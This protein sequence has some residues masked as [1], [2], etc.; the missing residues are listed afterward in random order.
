[1]LLL[2]ILKIL[3]SPLVNPFHRETHLGKKRAV[4]TKWKTA[5]IEKGLVSV[6]P[7][8]VKS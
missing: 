6:L 3:R 8:M 5:L 2:T 7:K 4:F 1:M